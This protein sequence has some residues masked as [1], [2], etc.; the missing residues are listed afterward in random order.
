MAL[1]AISLLKAFQNSHT[2]LNM[3]PKITNEFI[4]NALYQMTTRSAGD[5]VAVACEKDVGMGLCM[6][7]AS[8]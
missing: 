2:C 6:A 5:A 4:V 8:M 1:T 3:A 7:V